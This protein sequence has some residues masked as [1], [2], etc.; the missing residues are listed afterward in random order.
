MTGNMTMP[1]QRQ[2][3]MDALQGRLVELESEI[4][5]CRRSEAKFRLAAE[6]LPAAMVMVNELGQIVQVNAHTERLFGYSRDELL[7]QAVELLLPVRCR[8]GYPG[9][10][11]CFFAG[12]EA[13]EMGVGRNLFGQRKDGSEF[14]VEIG[15]NPLQTDDGSFVIS[16]IVDITERKR[17]EERFRR[18]VESAPN[19][20][21]MIDQVGRI[22]LV[23]GQ[24]EKLFGYPRNELL[25]QL[26]E[27]LVP[28]RFH[29]PH[30]GHRTN[31]FA[32]PEIRSMGVGRDLFGQRKD[33]SEFP[34]EIGL[35]PIETEE[36]LLVLSAIVDI[37]ERKLT[38]A[39]IRRLNED[40]EQRVRNR[41][42]QLETANKE[43]EAFSYS[44]SHDLRA[45]LRAIDGFSRILLQEYST[46]MPAEAQDFLRDVRANT[47][48][49]GH[50][51]D[52]LLSFSRV[53]RQSIKQQRVEPAG[54]VQRCLE[55]LRDQQMDRR[56]EVH[57]G[58]L[59]ACWG[60]VA[61]LKQVWMNLLSNALKYTARREVAIIG[62]GSHSGDSPGEQRYF[63]KDNGVGFDMRYA[64]KLFGVFQRLHPAEEYDGTGVGLAIVQRIILRHG[65]RVWAEAQP[66][67]GATFHFTLPGEGVAT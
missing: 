55:E 40:L 58:E 57:F 51:I 56:V 53:G 22:V 26:V 12:P 36:G 54:L 14:P 38:E 8:G 2:R 44:V 20:M 63:V 37:T 1:D 27:L 16:A 48:Q 33:G 65:G 39:Q 47:Q 45:P 64:E 29:G 46:A 52:D 32:K 4:E 34:V 59:A 50:L 35:T 7:G 3:D 30:P 66:D 42:V 19:A 15:L 5:K 23:N 67:K 28:K 43:L 31:F 9:F 61:L 49:M 17:A 6:S 13:R 62:I 11:E 21:V 10:R 24:T 25:G 18:V 41:T 60:D